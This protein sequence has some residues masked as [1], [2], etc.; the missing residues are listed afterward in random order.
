MTLNTLRPRTWEEYVGQPK[1][2]ARLALHIQAANAREEQLDHTLLIAPPGYGKTSL[3]ELVAQENHSEFQSFIMGQTKPGQLRD[4]ILNS[5]GT[6]LFDEFHKLKAADQEIF[7]PVLTDNYVQMPYGREDIRYPLTII[8]ATTE[9]NKVLQTIKERFKIA[10][11]FDDYTDEEMAL[12]LTG[13]ANRLCPGL[14]DA[15]S[16]LVLARATAGSPRQAE[17]LVFC[18]NDLQSG[19]P[20]KILE[21]SNITRDGLTRT[22][23]MYLAA[24]RKNN[25]GQ[26]GVALLASSLQMDRASVAEL[27]RLLAKKDMIEFTGQGRI[28]K[29]LGNQAL[30][31]N[32]EML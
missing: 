17:M 4:I 19:D 26:A 28:L 2:K 21:F 14:I 13:M 24:L 3:A 5:E 9:R 16:A 29:Y 18:A 31:K 25:G 6:V 8:V 27:E 15:E 11:E 20:K 7:L 22:H 23:L 12:I 1:L 30:T 32:K 10:P